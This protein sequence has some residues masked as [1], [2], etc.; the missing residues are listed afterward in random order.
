MDL[1]P[2]EIRDIY[3][4]QITESIDIFN[5]KTYSW[6]ENKFYK[7]RFYHDE[8]IDQMIKKERSNV[9]NS[10]I[11][12]ILVCVES[13]D[14]YRLTQLTHQLKEIRFTKNISLSEATQLIY[15]YD[16]YIQ[17][18]FSDF[19]FLQSIF[20]FMI[21]LVTMKNIHLQLDW[22]VYY[23]IFLTFYGISKNEFSAN[24]SEK[25]IRS[26]W[27]CDFIKKA[28]K[29][30]V[31]S[32]EDYKFLK[33]E[34]WN[35]LVSIE[36]QLVFGLL[37]SQLFLPPQLMKDDV[38]F[39]DKLMVILD[40]QT[41]LSNY[42]LLNFSKILKHGI[43]VDKEKFIEK[44]FSLS[45][46]LLSD[47]VSFT[48][49][50]WPDALYKDRHTNISIC[51]ILSALFIYEDFQQFKEL[52]YKKYQILVNLI[53]AELTE[54]NYSEFTFTFVKLF[55]RNLKQLSCEVVD[56]EISEYDS[57]QEF[58]L[59]N[60]DMRKR[61]NEVTSYLQPILSKC[62]FY[63][64]S[65][66]FGVFVEYINLIDTLE[67]RKDHMD[68]INHLYDNSAND[69]NFFM[70]K[71]TIFLRSLIENINNSKTVE[72]FLYEIV[73]TSINKISCI[74]GTMNKNILDFF[75]I[76]YRVCMTKRDQIKLQDGGA[77]QH[78][79]SAF[80]KFHD[81]L[82]EKSVQIVKKIMQLYSLFAN[83]IDEIYFSL[84]FNNL[85]EFVTPEAMDQ[86]SLL[87]SEYFEN[88]TLKEQS[89]FS[90]L[91]YF[92]T[93]LN[94]KEGTKHN[95]GKNIWS[96]CYR[97]M[98]DTDPT[99]ENCTESAQKASS[100][101]NLI[102]IAKVGNARLNELTKDMM[103]YMKK[104]LPYLDVIDDIDQEQ[105]FI[106]VKLLLQEKTEKRKLV[107]VMVKYICYNILIPTVDKGKLQYPNQVK[108]DFLLRYYETI[109]KPYEELLLSQFSCSDVKIEN[110]KEFEEQIIIYLR[111]S[112]GYLNNCNNIFMRDFDF[113]SKHGEL[114]TQIPEYETYCKLKALKLR[115]VENLLTF[116]EKAKELSCFEKSEKYFRRSYF[117][118]FVELDRFYHMRLISNY[119]KFIVYYREMKFN[120]FHSLYKS[121]LMVANYSHI[122]LFKIQETKVYY[123]AVRNILE[124]YIE[125]EDKFIMGHS[126]FKVALMLGNMVPDSNDAKSFFCSIMEMVESKLNQIPISSE[127][128]VTDCKKFSRTVDVLYAVVNVHCG[129]ISD[130]SL[131]LKYMYK[132][133]LIVDKFKFNTSD[134][135][136]SLN[137]LTKSINYALPKHSTLY[138]MKLEEMVDP[139]ILREYDMSSHS[140]ISIEKL[141]S[142]NSL[143]IVQ[144]QAEITNKKITNKKNLRE[145]IESHIEDEFDSS[146]YVDSLNL[147]VDFLNCIKL[148]LDIHCK[149]DREIL[150]KLEQHYF[151]KFF[152]EKDFLKKRVF[153]TGVGLVENA[154][155]RE[156]KS[157]SHVLQDLSS[158]EEIQFKNKRNFYAMR[159]VTKNVNQYKKEITPIFEELL[160]SE[161]GIVQLITE[162]YEFQEN[163]DYMNMVS[164]SSS[165][166]TTQDMIVS[167]LNYILNPQ[168]SDAILISERNFFISSLTDVPTI[169]NIVLCRILFHIFYFSTFENYD[170]IFNIFE[171]FKKAGK[172]GEEV[173]E[174][175]S[176]N[177]LVSILYALFKKDRISKNY[178]RITEN[179]KRVMSFYT[180]NFNKRIDSE[181][182]N[183][184]SCLFR[185]CTPE[186]I[187]MILNDPETDSLILF[188]YDYFFAMKSID[189]MYDRYLY[190]THLIF[191]GNSHKL[192]S[193]IINKFM[194]DTIQWMKFAYEF[195]SFY[196]IYIYINELVLFDNYHTYTP[197]YSEKIV[198]EVEK[199]HKFY[200]ENP[201]KESLKLLN[202][203]YRECIPYLAENKP[204]LFIDILQE[205]TSYIRLDPK[206]YK[207]RFEYNVNVF[208]NLMRFKPIE[209]NKIINLIA[210]KISELNHPDSVKF[211]TD[212]F[213][214]LLIPRLSQIIGN[215]YNIFNNLTNLVNSIKYIECKEYFCHCVLLFVIH[216]I[217]D[218]INKKIIF[219]MLDSV[220]AENKEKKPCNSLITV[221][222]TFLL[223][224]ELILKAST[225]LVICK[226]KEI[227]KSLFRN[228]GNES[229]IIKKCISKF[230]NRYSYTYCYVKKQVSEE[231]QLAIDELSKSQSYFI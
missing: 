183:L 78:S 181:I 61:I 205:M 112:I 214:K 212:V 102:N 209:F 128:L 18:H 5:E 219:N 167:R 11:N 141:I 91:I 20:Y 213:R 129:K 52:I 133:R 27:L 69:Y 17:K 97:T 132:F 86:I 82:V 44:V 105:F 161:E 202:V 2:I 7:E 92:L 148:S 84:F 195:E 140:G 24:Y 192:M 149:E 158:E 188:N 189:L 217:D 185:M 85:A 208:N 198:H 200:L 215:E 56:Y 223:N 14:I 45:Y 174:V 197:K 46:C 41:N 199:V 130:I 182:F 47:G 116:H 64:D 173:N 151:K 107:Y 160:K 30:F 143:L 166:Y 108:L 152:G 22:K 88:T 147:M 96:F 6:V 81:K 21:D 36:G 29:F 103:L 139:Y 80:I 65:T 162:I 220:K 121:L 138:K 187:K 145:F 33:L 39:Q 42:V 74:S 137:Q 94:K 72:G 77:T 125:N 8:A 60:E 76:L 58:K 55:L 38:E 67:L 118:L 211:F 66:T 159:S 34:V 184:F 134:S 157:V 207:A 178:K 28:N 54:N 226:F 206:N 204:E 203:V 53:N 193:G 171:S 230:Y 71:I 114:I 19:N 126:L 227:N 175:V 51:Y 13:D 43:K 179:L 168:F 135:L 49:F 90:F 150:N 111:L 165:M 31:F 154:K 144:N 117:A 221:L 1:N 57:F 59:T 32:E 115:V 50:N 177:V 87:I 131:L 163:K 68:I 26:V 83:I 40:N 70:K 109:V 79:H 146:N 35:R 169:F 172:S 229:K 98:V 210:L 190:R 37:I 119:R 16:L 89:E 176:V 191:T 25:Y 123:K 231:C 73:E 93:F 155:F 225:E 9:I 170:M 153:L 10:W 3:D 110:K 48:Y 63:S 106:L 12:K 224:Y 62:L 95:I 216:G 196:N 113:A 23:K 120:E 201:R 222:T 4:N 156:C 100:G 104:L 136:T 101:K 218:E 127:I 180:N 186:E 164:N 228:N 99:I 15:I 75:S 142:T 122:K 194:L 124:M